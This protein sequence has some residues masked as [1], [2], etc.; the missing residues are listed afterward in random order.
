MSKLFSMRI[1]AIL[2]QFARV[3][4]CTDAFGLGLPAALSAPVESLL[5]DGLYSFSVCSQ[6]DTA[7]SSAPMESPSDGIGL[8]LPAASC[9]PIE[10]PSHGIGLRLPAASSARM[11]LDPEIIAQGRRHVPRTRRLQGAA[12]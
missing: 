4:P 6:R 12:R 9:A 11:E 7:A 10:S 2:A 8:G 5:S 3:R 1:S